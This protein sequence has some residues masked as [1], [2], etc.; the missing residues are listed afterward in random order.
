MSTK[1]KVGGVNLEEKHT[2]ID[3]RLENLSPLA[4]AMDGNI[5]VKSEDWFWLQEIVERQQRQIEE[6]IGSPFKIIEQQQEIEQLRNL[7]KE[8]YKQGRFDEHAENLQLEEGR[9]FLIIFE[10]DD[11]I[12][13][14]VEEDINRPNCPDADEVMTAWVLDNVGYKNFKAY[15]LGAFEKFKA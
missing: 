8:M 1:K 4:V 2:E 7:S 12:E 15:E 10:D 9:L 11:P 5:L 6:L 3:E 14:F 13:L